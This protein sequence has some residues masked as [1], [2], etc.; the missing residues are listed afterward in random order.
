MPPQ[1]KLMGI[2]YGGFDDR[3]K[4]LSDGVDEQFDRWEKISKAPGITGIPTGLDIDR[5]LGGLQK[6][7]LVILAAR[8][9]AGKTA[10]ALNIACNVCR[11]GK[12]VGMFSLEMSTPQLIDRMVSSESRVD[13]FRFRTGDLKDHWTTINKSAAT[14]SEWPLHIDDTPGLSYMEIR[15]RARQLKKKSGVD[16]IIID[17]LQ[18]ASGDRNDGRTR[19]V[20]SIS[21]N[22][23]HMAKEL[24]IPVLL[25]SQL[26][27]A[28]DSRPNKRPILSDLRDSGEIEQDADVVIFIY[29]SDIYWDKSKGQNPEIG[30]AEI[31]VAKHRNG[32][33]GM[34]K[35]SFLESYTRFE[36]MARTI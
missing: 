4:L 3:F 36:N 18:L 34:K 23:K 24:D 13:S 14:M 35:V 12:R 28:V 2:N 16:L 19:E 21:R 9:S 6:T 32:P 5:I 7:D 10:L 22:M 17:Y 31:A 29:R 11:I 25:L 15:R 27:R 26:S 33:I 30:V 8:P 1:T 20:G